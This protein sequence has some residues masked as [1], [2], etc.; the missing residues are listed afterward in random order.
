[1]KKEK[2]EEKKC[3]NGILTTRTPAKAGVRWSKYT[4]INSLFFF[5]DVSH[6]EDDLTP[7]YAWGAF[8]HVALTFVSMAGVI[9]FILLLLYMFLHF[10]PFF[11]SSHLSPHW[12]ALL[13][14][15]VPD[16]SWLISVNFLCSA[17]G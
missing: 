11:L 1:M 16:L 4:T 8:F 14:H 9:I 13:C 15:T 17:V 2:K 5:S 6:D 10:F 3:F 12:G 7:F